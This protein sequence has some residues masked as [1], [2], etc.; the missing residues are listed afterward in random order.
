MFLLDSYALGGICLAVTEDEKH[1]VTKDFRTLRFCGWRIVVYAGRCLS[2]FVCETHTHSGISGPGRVNGEVRPETVHSAVFGI[3]R[4]VKCVVRAEEEVGVRITKVGT[5]IDT[6]ACHVTGMDAARRSGCDGYIVKDR[7]DDIFACFVTDEERFAG[8]N[9]G[10]RL[11]LDIEHAVFASTGNSG[12][13]EPFESFIACKRRG[14]DLV[15]REAERQTEGV[16]IAVPPDSTTDGDGRSLFALRSI[17]LAVVLVC[18]RK[19]EY[20]LR[21]FG[22][23]GEVGSN[24]C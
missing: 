1:A 11:Q 15:S 4:P 8:S 6:V 13:T 14:C 16:I 18:I 2:G 20:I 12:S 3:L 17:D 21:P 5:R 24:I 19:R 10:Y 23:E 7:I 22:I 9:S